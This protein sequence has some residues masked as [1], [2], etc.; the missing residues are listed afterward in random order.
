METVHVKMN[1]LIRCKSNSLKIY[2]QCVYVNLSNIFYFFL[3]RNRGS[4]DDSVKVN[5]IDH[6][7]FD[8]LKQ[9]ILNEIRKEM[10]KIKLE[11][12]EGNSKRKP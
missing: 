3:L 7:E 11:I 6:L 2:C 1:Q 9:D 5:G 8:R 4:N 12:I 10:N